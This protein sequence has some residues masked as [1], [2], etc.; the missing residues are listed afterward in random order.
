MASDDEADGTLGGEAKMWIPDDALKSLVTERTLN[1]QESEETLS[2]RLF[3]ENAA[4]ATVSI[5]HTALHGTNE[6]TRLDASKYIV[7]RVL[8]RVGDDA[9]GGEK[10]PVEAFLDDVVVE[11]EAYAN[12]ASNATGASTLGHESEQS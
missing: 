6:R 9:F 2:R 10:S 12:A 8:G 5:I 4:A 3:T 1:P 7:E 11:V